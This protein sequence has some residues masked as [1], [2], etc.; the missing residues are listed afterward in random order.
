M[1]P[2]VANNDCF[3]T[4][5]KH[6]HQ[7]AMITKNDFNWQRQRYVQNE[8]IKKREFTVLRKTSLLQS[9]LRIDDCCETIDKHCNKYAMIKIRGFHLQR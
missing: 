4:I 5:D 6:F 9:N 2:N 8:Y 7:F 1:Q 3:E